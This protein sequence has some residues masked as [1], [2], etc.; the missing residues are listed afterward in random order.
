V[1]DWDALFQAV[2]QRLAQ[3]VGHAGASQT[4]AGVL[5]CVA[6]LDKLSVLLAH[7]RAHRQEQ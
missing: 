7:E 3:L 5:E 6:A 2:C 1:S 4:Q